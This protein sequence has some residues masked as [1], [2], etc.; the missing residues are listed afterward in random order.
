MPIHTLLEA[1]ARLRDPA[2]L[3]QE[4]I[5]ELMPRMTLLSTGA[6]RRLEAEQALQNLQAIRLFDASS[7]K[8]WRWSLW[9]NIALFFLTVAAVVIAI[10]SYRAAERSSAQQQKTLDASRG[11]LEAAVELIGD[12]DGLCLLFGCWKVLGRT[13]D[14]AGVTTCIHAHCWVVG[15]LLACEEAV[16]K[17]CSYAALDCAVQLPE[18]FGC[19]LILARA[20]MQGASATTTRIATV[21]C[22]P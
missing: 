7:Q 15:R 14:A 9:L 6:V 19:E 3:T 16:H 21:C 12:P 20:R 22:R 2:P 17:S 11:A 1:E 8:I 5:R 10:G 4:D 18:V 13:E